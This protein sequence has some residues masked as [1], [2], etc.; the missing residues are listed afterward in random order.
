MKKRNVFLAAAA[1]SLCMAFP[2]MA[3]ETQESFREEA[4]AI[5]AQMQELNAQIEPLREENVEMSK[6]FKEFTAESKSTGELPV[7]KEVWDEIQELRKQISQYRTGRGAATV[8]AMR[9]EAKQA[10][11][12]GDY[13]AALEQMEAVLAAKQER[14]EQAQEANA[15]WK[16]IQAILEA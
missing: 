9:A 1:L 7:D 4:G 8:K 12:E 2:A 16:E 13:A 15:L 11:E 14:L 10:A 3:N 5:H 6:A